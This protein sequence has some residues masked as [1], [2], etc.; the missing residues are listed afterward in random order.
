M[1]KQTGLALST[2]IFWCI[3]IAL[4]AL[5]GMKLVPSFLEY[6]SVLKTV[7]TVV[8]EA[9]P[10]ATVGDIRKAFANYDSVNDFPS[11][12][13]ADLEITKDAGQLVVSFA[14]EKRIPLVANISLVIDFS[15]SSN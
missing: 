14:Y 7:K 2:L 8:N 13:A 11:V 4:V 6:Q 9:G 1:N 12:D 10:E 3:G 15:G 5:V